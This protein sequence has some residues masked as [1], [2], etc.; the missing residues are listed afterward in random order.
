MLPINLIN[1]LAVCLLSHNTSSVNALH[2]AR[3]SADAL[4]ILSR[5]SGQCKEG[6]SPCNKAGLPANFC[7]PTGQQCIAFNNDK[8]AICCPKGQDCKKIAPISCDIT[9]QNAATSPGSGIHSTELTGKLETCGKSCCPKGYSCKDDNCVLQTPASTSKASSTASSTSSSTSTTS[10]PTKSAVPASNSTT[11]TEHCSQYPAK[12]VAAGVFAGILLG[13]I[14]TV[15]GILI[16]GRRNRKKSEKYEES[17]L[18][19]V[20]QPSISDPIPPQNGELRNDFLRHDPF[21]TQANAHT[22]Y[23]RSRASSRVRSL[24]ARSPRSPHHPPESPSSTQYSTRSPN[25]PN[26]NGHHLQSPMQT[27]LRR[28]P[29]MESIKIYSPPNDGLISPKRPGTTFSGM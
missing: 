26:G 4:R 1:L 17:K 3:S 16:L 13:G 14:L 29:S 25:S 15:A 27:P 18:G 2:T 24:F 5:Q 7:C 9:K 12:A 20:G 19:S 22:G 6:S 10:S 21:P 28:E 11:T 8:S 23:S